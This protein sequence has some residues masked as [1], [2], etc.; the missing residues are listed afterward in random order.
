MWRPDSPALLG[1]LLVLACGGHSRDHAARDTE[2]GGSAGVGGSSG[3]SG[4]RGGDAGRA[5]MTGGA[6]GTGGA[7]GRSGAPS[8]GSGGRDCPST[9]ADFCQKLAYSTCPDTRS[10]AWYVE[11]ICQ[12]DA[13]DAVYSECRDGTVRFTWNV[14]GEN[15]YELVYSGEELVYGYSL[16]YPGSVCR[17]G[18]RA[19]A[20]DCASCDFCPGNAGAGGAG[21]AGLEACE[22]LSDGTVSL[23]R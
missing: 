21:G 23:P 5:S 14:A 13:V 15:D 1:F 12:L 11:R 9:P 19:G 16:N 10:G 6:G 17:I 20:A 8:G 18:A 4:H 7:S 3:G 22:F 2:D